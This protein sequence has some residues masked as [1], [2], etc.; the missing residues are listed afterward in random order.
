MILNTLLVKEIVLWCIYIYY[1]Y[2][3]IYI[4]IYV[5][6]KT[7]CPPVI[8]TVQWLCSNSSTWVHDVRLHIAGTDESKS[9]Q[10]A[11]QGV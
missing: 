6:M 11:K 8:T 3:Y 5:I 1:I 7:M 2:I 4:C 9:A 10:Q